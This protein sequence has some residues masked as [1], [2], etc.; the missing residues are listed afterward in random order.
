MAKSDRMT[1]R[2]PCHLWLAVILEP[3]ALLFCREKLGTQQVAWNGLA[4]RADSVK[5]PPE[6]EA[7]LLNALLGPLEHT[8]S[9]LPGKETDAVSDNYHSLGMQAL[10][11][12]LAAK[13]GVGIADMIVKSL[14]KRDHAGSLNEKSPAR[15][16]SL[17]RPF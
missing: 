1:R 7:V 12:T 11:S 14:S 8:F 10:T 4:E 3:V 16:A 17:A 13:G 9:S 6:F 2:A 5:I 15:G